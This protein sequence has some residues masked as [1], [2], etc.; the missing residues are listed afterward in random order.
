[1]WRMLVFKHNQHQVNKARTISKLMKFQNFTHTKVNNL[2]DYSGNGDGT[3][4][5]T[6]KG[7][8]HTLEQAD[9]NNYTANVGTAYPDSE[10]RCRYGHG[11]SDITL[12]IDSRGVVH[13]CC[14]HQSRLRFFYPDFYINNDPKP[15]V[16]G[17]IDNQCGG[18]GGQ[19]QELYR[20]TII[21]L[22]ELQGGITSMS[23]DYNNLEK[24]LR[25][26]FYSKTLVQS[27]QGLSLI[28][29]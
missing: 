9:D 15:A 28:H 4:T 21:P 5:Y 1:M 3:Y 26:P 7:E 2:Y 24:I 29:I 6:H 14:Y 19:L 27:W 16:F 8:T 12:R 22:I 11:T 20:E 23:L 10:I 17:A 13:A 25:S 18:A